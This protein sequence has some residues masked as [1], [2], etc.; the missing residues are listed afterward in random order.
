MVDTGDAVGGEEKA[1]SSLHSL[2]SGAEPPGSTSTSSPGPALLTGDCAVRS[3]GMQCTCS[4]PTLG[5]AG[6]GMRTDGLREGAAPSRLRGSQPE[7]P[8]LLGGRTAG[9][10][11]YS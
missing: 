8:S 2:F 1:V 9:R 6:Q 7:L 11:V 4:V 10:F 5:K 3:V